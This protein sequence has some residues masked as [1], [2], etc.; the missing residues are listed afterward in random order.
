MPLLRERRG[1]LPIAGILITIIIAVVGGL[2]AYYWIVNA[3][4]STRGHGEA[5][6]ILKAR[7][8]IEGARIEGLTLIVIVRNIGEVTVTIDTVAIGK[9]ESTYYMLNV[10]GGRVVIPAGAIAEVRAQLPSQLTS[11]VYKVKVYTEDGISAVYP[12]L[13]YGGL[14]WLQGWTYRRPIIITEKSGTTLTDYQVRIVLTPDNFDYSKTRS[15]GGDIRFTDTDGV[16]QLP[17]WI[18]KWD[19]SGTSIIWV[20]VPEIPANSEKK[21][22]MYYGNLEATSQSNGTEV[23]EFFDDFQAFDQTRWG[24]ARNVID[25]EVSI[26]S[27]VEFHDS[28]GLRI[29]AYYSSWYQYLNVYGKQ[30]WSI[31]QEAYSYI[32]ETRISPRTKI[33]NDAE[34]NLYTSNTNVG[35]HPENADGAQIH[36]S[37]DNYPSVWVW[38]YNPYLKEQT[39][40]D[41]GGDKTYES[42]AWYVLGI[43]YYNGQTVY[44]IWIDGDYTS[45]Y[46]Y[47]V[48][49]N[50][51]T[52]FRIVLGNS[53][54]GSMMIKVETWVDWVRIRKYIDPEPTATI[55]SEETI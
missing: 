40:W 1:I 53:V 55:G 31:P 49:D 13:Y 25:Y 52:D 3:F 18:E 35:V 24:I 33:A 22:Y 51:Y 29:Y 8:K 41:N 28:T 47:K 5:G 19:P 43:T 48:Y 32:V 39:V 14:T 10:E 34:L 16:T 37:Y 4:A 6:G 54:E 21:I 11:G 30:T 9:S 17:Y 27:D 38:Y 7:L 26:I 50:M 12:S 23:F 46:A 44:Y 42:G 45:P 20:K 2:I 36:A 15:D